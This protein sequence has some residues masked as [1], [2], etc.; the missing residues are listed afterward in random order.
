[1][2]AIRAS[3]LQPSRPASARWSLATIALAASVAAILVGVAPACL[4]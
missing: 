3:I 1:M 2:D 4:S